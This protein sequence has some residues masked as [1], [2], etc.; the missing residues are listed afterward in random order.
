M[1]NGICNF[2]NNHEGCDFDGEDCLIECKFNDSGNVGCDFYNNFP[3]CNWDFGD[4]IYEN[5]GCGK[6]YLI[7]DGFCQNGNN[8][9]ECDFDGGDCINVSESTKIHF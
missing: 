3:S 2:E 8:K 1:G 9:S 5:V 4:C 7:G 6:S